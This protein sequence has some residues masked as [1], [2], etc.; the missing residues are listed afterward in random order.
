MTTVLLALDRS[1]L[2]SAAAEAAAAIF[3]PD[4]TYLAINVAADPE[5]DAFV[6]GRVYGYP[7]PPVVPANPELV[8]PSEAVESAR[9]AA[10]RAA[11]EAGLDDAVALG[12]V[13]D[14]ADAIVR[15]AVDHRV[16]VIVVG[17]HDRSWLANLLEGSVTDQLFASTPVPLLVV[18]AAH[19]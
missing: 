3:G 7:Y 9:L 5:L 14:P 15:A 19:D 12:A 16:D 4:A 1:S 8:D 6:W 11:S 18:P 17:W 2:A 13:G 10:S